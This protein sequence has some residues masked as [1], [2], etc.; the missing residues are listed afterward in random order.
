MSTK[1]QDD[2]T[3]EQGSDHTAT[4]ESLRERLDKDDVVILKDEGEFIAIRQSDGAIASADPDERR[5]LRE[6]LEE[7]GYEVRE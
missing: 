3:M 1:T 7:H 6:T 2:E 4:Y 5:Q